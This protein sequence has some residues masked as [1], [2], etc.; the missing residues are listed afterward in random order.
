MSKIGNILTQKLGFRTANLERKSYNVIKTFTDTINEIDEVNER[1]DKE[2]EEATNIVVEVETHKS[3]LCK[4]KEQNIKIKEK[5][6]S[7]IA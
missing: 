5:I 7:I 2:V 4:M 6:Q 1:I 3:K